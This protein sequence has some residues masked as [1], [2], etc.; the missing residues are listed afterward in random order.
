MSGG[1]CPYCPQARNP[2]VIPSLPPSLHLFHHL[3]V[4]LPNNSVSLSVPTTTTLFAVPAPLPV[5]SV[6]C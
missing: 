3:P 5:L 4:L 1:L 2:G 6:L